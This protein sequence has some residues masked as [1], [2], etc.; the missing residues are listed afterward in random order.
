MLTFGL[1][2]RGQLGRAG[3]F[4]D[5]DLKKAAG[6]SAGNCACAGEEGEGEDK[7]RPTSYGK[8]AVSWRLGGRDGVARFTDLG[9]DPVTREPRA[10]SFVAAG[11]YSIPRSSRNPATS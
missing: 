9:L 3:V 2:D 5:P 4:G 11:R 10:A 1:N 8:R 6:D 7:T